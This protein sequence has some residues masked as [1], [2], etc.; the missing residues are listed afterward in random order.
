MIA[1]A[2]FSSSKL[3]RKGQFQWQPMPATS[4]ATKKKSSPI[5]VTLPAAELTWLQSLIPY[6]RI[7]ISFGA[8]FRDSGFIR[9]AR[10]IFARSA[11]LFPTLKSDL[12][13]L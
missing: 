2:A 11:I 5:V 12:M 13:N 4:T 1:K 9:H 8:K 3:W 10:E 6:W 7:K